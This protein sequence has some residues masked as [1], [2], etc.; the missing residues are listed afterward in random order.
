MKNRLRSLMMLLI[1]AGT[2]LPGTAQEIEEPARLLSYNRQY[3]GSVPLSPQGA[4]FTTYALQVD[5]DVFAVKISLKNAPA[6]L[7]IYASYGS[8]IVDYG[9]ADIS[10]A[11]RDYNETLFLSRLSPKPLQTGV[12]YLDIV[13]QGRYA[14]L[15][16]YRRMKEIPFEIEAV[17]LSAGA[18]Q[19]LTADDPVYGELRPEDGMAMTFS[20]RVPEGIEQ[21]RVDIFDADANLDIVAGYEKPVPT[22]ENADYIGDSLV[23]NESIVFSGV[24]RYGTLPAGRYYITVFDPVQARYP[25][26]FGILVSF[27]GEAPRRFLSIPRF[28]FTDDELRHSI[29][30][31]VEV[32]GELGRGSGC[33]VSEDGL[34]LTSWHVVRGF[35]GE[36]AEDIAVAVSLSQQSPPEEMFRARVVEYDRETD[37]ALLEVRTGLYGQPLPYNYSFPF[38]PIGESYDPGIGQPISLLG[39][40]GAGSAGSRVSITLSRGIISGFEQRGGVPMIKTDTLVLPGNSGGAVINP[41]FELVGIVSYTVGEKGIAVGYIF[42]VSH[43]PDNWMDMI[44]NRSS[45]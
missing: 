21:C 34:I 33:L 23:G 25:E 42:P 2:C 6:D 5:E 29:H 41:Y 38:I 30:A 22:I 1:L 14:P 13:Y 31:T 20:L 43:I 10:Q 16:N 11:S 36:P 24:G 35:S 26:S 7:D 8:P 12:Y 28:P 40:P 19:T 15:Q 4:G 27:D 17:P 44:R 3:R 32:V 9:E 39:Y 37:L 45:F 18:R